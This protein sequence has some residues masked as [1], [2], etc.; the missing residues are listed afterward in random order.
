MKNKTTATL[1]AVFL[2][3]FG[4]HKFYLDKPIQGLFYILFSWTLI[5]AVV[6]LIEGLCYGTTSQKGFDEEF[7]KSLAQKKCPDCAE[8]IKVEA[9][10]CRYCGCS[11]RSIIIGE[12]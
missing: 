2:G 6:G 8:M 9:K 1:F 11:E 7:N 5:P 10:K 3:G 4:V 12:I